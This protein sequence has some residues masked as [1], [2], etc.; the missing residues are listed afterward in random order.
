MKEESMKLQTGTRWIFLLSLF[1][2]LSSFVFNKGIGAQAGRV[3]THT[4]IACHRDWPD[5]DPPI[6]DEIFLPVDMDYVPLNLVSS[7]A[8]DPFYTIPE[9]YVSSTHYTPSFNLLIKRSCDL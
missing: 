3:G 5:N 9:G 2:I 1:L 6:E 4:C 8:A 7:H